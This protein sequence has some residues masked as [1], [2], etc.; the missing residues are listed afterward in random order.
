MYLRCL[1]LFGLFLAKTL[2]TKKKNT[3]LNIRHLRH[4]N[5]DD[6]ITNLFFNLHIFI[7]GK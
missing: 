2:F 7:I 5:S 1:A 6:K 3:R 4:K